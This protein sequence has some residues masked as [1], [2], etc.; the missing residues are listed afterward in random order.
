MVLVLLSD[1][2]IE[3][4]RTIRQTGINLFL[5]IVTISDYT[6]FRVES[7]IKVS[8][9]PAVLLKL[10]ARFCTFILVGA[11]DQNAI[12]RSEGRFKVPAH[13]VHLDFHSSILTS[14]T[15]ANGRAPGAVAIAVAVLLLTAS[16][17]A[18]SLRIERDVV[19]SLD[20]FG[21]EGLC[22][23]ILGLSDHEFSLVLEF[24]SIVAVYAATV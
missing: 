23:Y 9:I 13:L 3:G 7:R 15:L 1:K 8:G 24:W 5:S 16:F 6:L 22:K 21:F 2:F 20:Y 12:L 19:F 14:E 4:R 10:V 11:E 17:A 18:T